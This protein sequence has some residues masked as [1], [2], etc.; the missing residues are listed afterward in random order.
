MQTNAN[1]TNRGKAVSEKMR[2]QSLQQRQEIQQKHKH[3]KTNLLKLQVFSFTCFTLHTLVILDPIY[4]NKD[5]QYWPMVEETWAKRSKEIA[6]TG[7]CAHTHTHTY[8]I[9]HMCQTHTQPSAHT[10]THYHGELPLRLHRSRQFEGVKVKV[11]HETTIN[12]SCGSAPASANECNTLT[13]M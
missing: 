12:N 5:I 3:C 1:D 13:H 4:K 9:I 10:N 11:Q 2:Y 7:L 8:G 6:L